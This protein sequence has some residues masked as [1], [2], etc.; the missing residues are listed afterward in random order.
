[1]DP[2]YQDRMV[3]TLARVLEAFAAERVLRDATA[4]VPSRE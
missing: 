4:S 3:E 2:A 1:V